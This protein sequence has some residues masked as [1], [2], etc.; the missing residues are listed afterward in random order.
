M[1][2]DVVQHSCTS[3]DAALEVV[4]QNRS[5]PPST[6]LD[7]S[8]LAHAEDSRGLG[9]PD[10]HAAEESRTQFAEVE[11]GRPCVAFHYPHRLYG[12]NSTGLSRNANLP[13]D[14]TDVPCHSCPKLPA[15]SNAESIFIY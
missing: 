8:R 14:A 10:V 6:C 2:R 7:D 12:K 9:G 13:V 15:E 11:F 5:L 1:A 3:I 4:D